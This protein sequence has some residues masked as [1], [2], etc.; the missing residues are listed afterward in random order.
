MI[1]GL[2]KQVRSLFFVIGFVSI[3]FLTNLF[4][5]VFCI[6]GEKQHKTINIRS[7][8]LNTVLYAFFVFSL[9]VLKSQSIEKT[10]GIIS[11]IVLCDISFDF[12]F[13]FI[14]N[15]LK[16][17]LTVKQL[18]L[19]NFK[20]EPF[21]P[22]EK[23]VS[24]IKTKPIQNEEKEDILNISHI[25]GIIKRLNCFSLTNIE[26]KQ[27]SELSACLQQVDNGVKDEKI[28]Q[29]INEGLNALL[30]IMAKYSI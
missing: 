24:L 5:T 30:K 13:K 11:F 16:I 17:I 27:V 10:L 6:K 20:T 1:Y 25:K 12:L 15:K 26:K 4:A 28:K 8:K 19:K 3:V 7:F 14:K 2:L 29:E 22:S 21:L 23:I 18:P 9:T